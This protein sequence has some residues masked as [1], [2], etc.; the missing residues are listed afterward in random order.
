VSQRLVIDILEPSVKV[1]LIPERNQVGTACK[2]TIHKGKYYIF[3]FKVWVDQNE[4]IQLLINCQPI[5]INC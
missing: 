5:I 3:I 4:F 2:C 1:L